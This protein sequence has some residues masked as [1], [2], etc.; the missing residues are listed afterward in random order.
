MTIKTI[1]RKLLSKISNSK[2]FRHP[3]ANERT[4]PDRYDYLMNNNFLYSKAE[5][6]ISSEYLD[7]AMPY[8]DRDLLNLDIKNWLNGDKRGADMLFSLITLNEFMKK[9]CA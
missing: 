5:D 2:K 3:S 4:W 7:V 1:L 6:L 9:V 8:I